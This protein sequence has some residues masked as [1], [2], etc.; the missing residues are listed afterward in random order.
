MNVTNVFEVFRRLDLPFHPALYHFAKTDDRV[1]RY[2]QI[3]AHIGQQGRFRM[4]GDLRLLGTMAEVIL[5]FGNDMIAK[6]IQAA[7]LIIG[8]DGLKLLREGD[9]DPS[10]VLGIG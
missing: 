5:A 10:T 8:K 1:Q 4:V 7:K 9:A 3:V 2:P 6:I